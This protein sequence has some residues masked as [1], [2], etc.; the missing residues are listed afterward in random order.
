M[1]ISEMTTV[2]A[3][4]QSDVAGLLRQIADSLNL[5]DALTALQV[6]SANH[7]PAGWCVEIAIVESTIAR[8]LGSADHADCQGSRSLIE[9]TS[10]LIEAGYPTVRT[11]P[12]EQSG[13]QGSWLLVAQPTNAPDPVADALIDQI[14][15]V[16]TLRLHNEHLRTALQQ[17]QA[18]YSQ[19]QRH[20]RVTDEVRMR[21]TLAA[22]AAHDIGNLLASVLGYVQL[23]QQQAPQA[24]QPDLRTVEQA[25]RDGNHLLRRVITSRLPFDDLPSVAISNL[26]QI[27][28]DAI[29]LTAPF[30]EPRTQ[31]VITTDIE[32]NPRVSANPTELREV[33]INLM[34]N[35]IAAMPEGGELA[36]RARQH[37]NQVV[38]E[39]SDTGMGI[40][41]AFQR[42]IFQPLVSTRE[43]G[44]GLGLSV[45]RTLIEQYGGTLD[46]ISAA[47]VGATFVIQLPAAR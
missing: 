10:A 6:L 9:I 23:L 19:L 36:I 1:I 3:V 18:Q 14:A 16:L 7:L 33:L 20:I 8:V 31:I 29:N 41:Q 15:T 38:I 2:M 42:A 24:L 35:G 28:A 40:E 5:D 11:L 37:G 39:V 34:L 4:P 32:S 12:L 27:I 26:R 47:G 17:L 25:A 22:G 44:S 13:D 30:W 46:V 43:S 45:S 21:A